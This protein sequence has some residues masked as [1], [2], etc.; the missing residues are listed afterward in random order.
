[1][2]SIQFAG[3]LTP[4]GQEVAR[5]LASELDR[6]L[7]QDVIVA[8]PHG[9]PT[10]SPGVLLVVGKTAKGGL[11][12]EEARA[13]VSTVNLRGKDIFEDSKSS[14]QLPDAKLRASPEATVR[15]ESDGSRA[16]AIFATYDLNTTPG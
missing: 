1:M 11:T 12:D 15:N 4:V 14:A 6:D 16:V 10:D 7:G 8:R 2:S 5:F 3:N 13:I 9:D